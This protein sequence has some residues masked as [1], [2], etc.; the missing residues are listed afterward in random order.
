MMM[1]VARGGYSEPSDVIN[2]MP[3]VAIHPEAGEN[4]GQIAGGAE[5][6][7]SEVSEA[8]EAM[9][10]I[11]TVAADSAN[12][13][14]VGQDEVSPP[15]SVIGRDG[16]QYKR[17][18]FGVLATENVYYRNNSEISTGKAGW[19]KTT[20]LRKGTSEGFGDTE[21]TFKLHNVMYVWNKTGIFH[22]KASK[23]DR[24]EFVGPDGDQWIEEVI[25]EKKAKHGRG[26][27]SART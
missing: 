13:E 17:Y 22:Q 7:N 4:R 15:I 3:P 11:S 23:C 9:T 18:L 20:T 19:K 1:G 8:S 5:G 26:N 2:S 6:S 12:E 16:L 21:E 24:S 14:S 27:Q 25:I 10:S